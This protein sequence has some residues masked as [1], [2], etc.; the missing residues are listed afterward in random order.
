[1]K[2]EN[3]KNISILLTEYSDRFSKLTQLFT[4]SKY[5]HAS[6]GIEEHN[7]RFYS[8]LTKG[9]RTEK[10][11][12]FAKFTNSGKS[13]ALYNLEVTEDVYDKVKA[14]LDEFK[15]NSKQYRYSFF[16]TILCF[17]RIPHK[18]KHR[19]FCSQFVAEILSSSGA[20]ELNKRP[21]LYQPKDFAKEPRLLLCFTGTLEE[22]AQAI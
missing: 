5:T 10:P 19:Y 8:F 7:D 21:S 1:M 11:G 4:A 9:F 13:C 17:L 3:K 18:F 6:I 2:S 16:G 15:N 20:I 22:L 14:Q 12:I